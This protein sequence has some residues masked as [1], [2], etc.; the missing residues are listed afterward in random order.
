MTSC[1]KNI[2]VVVF[3]DSTIEKGQTTQK[4]AAY[5]LKEI[6]EHYSESGIDKIIKIEK[7]QEEI[8]F[9]Y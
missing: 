2:W 9:W 3:S 5:S 6:L 7:T 4:L 8:T 1:T